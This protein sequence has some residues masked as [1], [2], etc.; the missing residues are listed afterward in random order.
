M[1]RSAEATTYL[2]EVFATRMIDHIKS[3]K[4]AVDTTPNMIYEDFFKLPA[5][6]DMEDDI[7][8]RF[9]IQAAINPCS[10]NYS[11][12]SIMV[13]PLNKNHIL[14]PSYVRGNFTDTEIDKIVAAGIANDERGTIDMQRLKVYGFFAKYKHNAYFDYMTLF[15]SIQLSAE[16][17]FAITLHELKH[18]LDYYAYADRIDTVN[19]R[20]AEL[21][22]DKAKL[23]PR[24]RMYALR[25]IATGLNQP[26]D[27]FDSVADAPLGVIFSNKLFAALFVDVKSLYGA[28]DYDEVAGEQLADDLATRF[29]FGKELVSA[30][31]KIHIYYGS[32]EKNT[33]NKYMLYFGQIFMKLMLTICY[34]ILF[35]PAAPVMVLIVFLISI[36]SGGVGGRGMQG[37]YDELKIRYARIREAIIKDFVM[38]HH[39]SKE[40]AI[41]L[42]NQLDY[43]AGVM[44]ATEV[45]IWYS[46]TDRFVNMVFSTPGGKRQAYVV[47]RLLEELA[48]N[49]M[50]VSVLRLKQ[51]SN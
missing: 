16:E 29:G 22:R 20:L 46:F 27:Y 36:Y 44:E 34:G 10:L 49:E 42:T 5:L 28:G 15:K 26:E 41:R 8:T 18:V 6:Q 45:G 1:N 24:E 23:T 14:L 9:G 47:Q 12:A 35:G 31:D 30:L 40:D 11:I 19:Q 39:I 7:K 13:A 48:A 33:A 25:E 43:I 2:G 32:P 4:I 50:W 51:I 21:V 3:I 37:S 38:E 17:V